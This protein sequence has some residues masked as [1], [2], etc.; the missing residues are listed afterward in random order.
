MSLYQIFRPAI[1]KLDPE[2]AHNLAIKLLKFLPNSVTLLALNRDY[3]N[4]H[5]SLWNL[6]FANPI[7]MAAGFDKNAEVATALTKFGFGFVEVGTVTP[8]AQSGNA[9][10]RMFRLFED[11][12]IINRLGFNNL[13]AQNF[14]Q[15]IAKIS[16]KNFIP[17]GINIGKNKDTEN[18]LLDY[19]PLLEKFYE[20]A[21]Y[22]T[23]N[24]S[25]PNT[26]NL[27]DL[28][29]EDQ[30]DLFLNE[31]AK[32]KNELKNRSKKNTPILLKVAPDLT[33]IEQEKIAEIVLKNQLDG[34]IVSNTT[35]DR[36]LNLK[37]KYAAETG[38]LS[39]APLF[40]KSN[41]A[42]RNFYKFTKGQVPLVGVGGISCAAEAYE[43]I[44]C[45][46]SLVQIYSAFIYQG[47]GLVEK[48]KQELSEMIKKDGF[49]NISQAIG[50]KK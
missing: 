2:N 28:Q 11:L 46:A 45:G 5:N 6:D 42:L 35:I 21:G 50:S 47:F 48:I 25:S 15:N 43:K 39:G 14:E 8:L 36:N 12:A 9:K 40:E 33:I 22:I 19:L 10:P 16:P 23:I 17:L 29:K 49:E 37:S 4:L 20:K 44:K 34:I 13:G 30:L 26:Q 7:G 24:I 18:A 31:I 38:G 41:E 3:K 1:F 27:R 32:K